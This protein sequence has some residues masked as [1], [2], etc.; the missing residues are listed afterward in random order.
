VARFDTKADVA[1]LTLRAQILSGE[2]QAGSTLNQEVLAGSL[3]LSTTPLRE[4]LRRLEAENLVTV[5]AHRDLTVAP[6][7]RRELAELLDIRLQLDPHACA[8]AA[9]HASE[10]DI[11]ATL[12]LAEMPQAMDVREQMGRHR[13]F[14]RSMYAKS[15]NV[16]LTQVLDS[17]W[18]RT[19][20]YR[21]LAIRQLSDHQRM[22]AEHLEIAGAFRERRA[23]HLAA[24]I[25]RHVQYSHQLLLAFQ[26]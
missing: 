24:L 6:L 1:Y 3:G 2:L 19:D 21:V 8:L 4:A 23:R 12:D 5:Q 18:D 26:D 20:R 22:R 16:L 10:R 13:S 17:L 15:G 11:E 25:R 9:R 14:H 7:S